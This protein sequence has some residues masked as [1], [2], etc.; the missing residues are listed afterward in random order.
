VERLRQIETAFLGEHKRFARRKEVNERQHI[1]DDLDQRSLAERANVE[2]LAAHRFK[3]GPMFGEKLR[4]PTDDDRNIARRRP[5]NAAGDR[6]FKRHNSAGARQSGHF[7]EFGSVV[8]AH[9]N[10]GS[11]WLQTGQN[12]AL[13]RQ[14]LQ[15]DARRGQAGDHGVD[16]FSDGLGVGRPMR[17]VSDEA[18][19][20]G[21]IDVC[22]GDIEPLAHQAAGEVPS[23]IS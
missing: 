14:H 21:L 7:L 5:M 16:P 22:D 18:R 17:A 23:E 4:I 9:L 1:S 3:R 20:R 6:R 10:P 15:R 12:A 11:A 8:R 13:A 19:G 2:N